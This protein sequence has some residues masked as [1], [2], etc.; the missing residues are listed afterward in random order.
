M[1]VRVTAA[2]RK[3]IEW[4]IAQPPA[5][6]RP[7]LRAEQIETPPTTV[8]AYLEKIIGVAL[9]PI[10]RAKADADVQADDKTR[11]TLEGRLEKLTVAQ[12]LRL[13][14]ELAITTDKLPCGAKGKR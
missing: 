2:Q 11:K 13:A 4:A 5:P 6:L 1:Q 3:A 8:E 9:R 12:C 14:S 7:G 10:V